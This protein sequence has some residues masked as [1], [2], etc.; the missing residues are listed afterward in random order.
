M[1]RSRLVHAVVVVAL[2]VPGWF[3]FGGRV[4]AIQDSEDKVWFGPIGV[5][6]G[7]GVRINVYGLGSRGAGG[8][9]PVPTVP[10]DFSVRIFNR[11]GAMV[12]DRRFQ[13]APGAIASLEVNI[14]NPDEFPLDRL[15][16]RTLRAEV[17]GISPPP[18]PDQPPPDRDKYAATLEVY[19]QFTGHTRILIGTPGTMPDAVIATQP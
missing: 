15:G 7:Q 16:R 10:W 6:V 3:V 19:S 8:I 1:F 12:Q 9:V 11:Q 5:G 2:L 4:L 18:D 17:I 13:V 14:G